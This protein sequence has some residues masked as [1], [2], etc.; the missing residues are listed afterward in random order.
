MDS[1]KI[2]ELFLEADS[3][4]WDHGLT[5][6]K[7]ILKNSHCD[8]ATALLIFWRAQ[9]EYYYQNKLSDLKA[10]EKKTYKFLIELEESLLNNKFPNNISYDPQSDL[11]SAIDF[12]SMERQIPEV[13]LLKTQGEINYQD[14]REGKVGIG[15]WFKAA[16][17]GDLA[18]IKQLFQTEIVNKKR[19]INVKDRWKITAFEHLC[20]SSE[21]ESFDLV[22]QCML[23]FLE[24]KAKR[25][26]LMHV[27]GTRFAK[28]KYALLLENGMDINTTDYGRNALH[29]VKRADVAQFLLDQ[30]ID[31]HAISDNGQSILHE[32]IH[33]ASQ[34]VY[35]RTSEIQIAELCTL[36]LDAGVDPHLKNGSGKTALDFAKSAKDEYVSNLESMKHNPIIQKLD[37]SERKTISDDKTKQIKAL[38]SVISM[39]GE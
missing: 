5:K 33:R 13:L 38:D 10:A 4:N 39:L 35:A 18:L 27:S 14:I 9:P 1:D 20:K 11:L 15:S 37:E 31:V 8:Y 21:I 12:G 2:I 19:S 16:G 25:P 36:F 24:N 26:N 34:E 23:F 7:K 32:L 22:N 6:I 29:L 17:K 30:K 3:H 28:E